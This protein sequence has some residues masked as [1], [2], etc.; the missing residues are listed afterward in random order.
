M[1]ESML[2]VVKLG[3]SLLDWPQVGERFR[4]WLAEQP[5]AVNV[6]V[7]GGGALVEALREWDAVHGLEPA[8]M[9]ALCLAAMD[10]T[11]TLAGELLGA[12]VVDDV[13]SLPGGPSLS[14][15]RARP[16]L[17]D[18]DRLGRDPLPH[19]WSVT[20]DSIAARV[21]RRL[22]AAELVLLKSRLPAGGGHARALAAEGFVDAYF[23]RAWAGAPGARIV[24]LRS[25]RFVE[26][27]LVE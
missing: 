20:S 18:D 24:D 14:I 13:E 5:P 1:S 6:V 25:L 27:R 26:A 4:R 23:P 16:L 15:L 22:S 10:T 7:V 12:A 11:A 9:H 21:A 3:G 17:D 19:D 8:R 2:R